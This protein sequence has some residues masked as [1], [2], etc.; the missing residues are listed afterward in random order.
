MIIHVNSTKDHTTLIY[1]HCFT[2]C[3]LYIWFMMNLR[4]GAPT[5][6]GLVGVLNILM[7]KKTSYGTLREAWRAVHPTSQGWKNFGG[8]SHPFSSSQAHR[9]RWISLAPMLWAKATTASAAPGACAYGHLQLLLWKTCHEL[10]RSCPHANQASDVRKN[11][12]LVF[13]LESYV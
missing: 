8:N 3:L 2:S 11:W 4:R 6:M 10:N 9:L 12:N 1:L 13:K 5:H 7:K